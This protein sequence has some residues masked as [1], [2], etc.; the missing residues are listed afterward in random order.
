MEEKAKDARSYY[1]RNKYCFGLGTVGRDALYSLVSMF[2][3]VYLT[4]VVGVS[5]FYLGIITTL[6]FVFRVIDSVND[7][8]VGTFV[9]N[10]NTK[11]GKF[12]PWI[13]GGM[14]S[15][16]LLT[17]LLFHNFDMHPAWYVVLFAITYFLWSTAYTANDI[18]YWSLMPALSKDPKE[19]EGIGAISRICASVGMFAVVLLFTEVPKLFAPLGLDPRN[20]YFLFAIILISI[21]KIHSE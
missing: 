15:A 9:D 17:V 20:S 8:F 5:N 7:P 21:S 12:K 18:S 6:L 2:L 14:I 13:F 4:E 10:T 16:G 1:K 11:W 3:M 19:R